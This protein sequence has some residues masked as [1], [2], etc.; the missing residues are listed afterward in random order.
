M[1]LTPE[2]VKSVRAA[3]N[4][5]YKK[6][7]RAHLPWRETQ[8]PYHILVSEVMLQQTQVERVIPYF[9][10]WVE[11]FPTVEHLSRAPL[12]RVLQL[13][14]GLGYNR[15]AAFLHRAAQAVVNEWGGV[16]PVAYDG[17]RTL[18]G[19]GEYTAKA[20]RV[21]AHNQPET[22][23]ETNV[24]TVVI[25]HCFSTKKNISEDLI[26]RVA[27]LLA[28]GQDPRE[29]HSALMDYGT[30]LKGVVGNVSRNARSYTK[31][32]PLKGSVREVRGLILKQLRHGSSTRTRLFNV[33]PESMHERVPVALAGLE[34]DGLVTRKKSTYLLAQ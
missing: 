7:R 11:T 24:R 1:K 26:R 2:Q 13:W 30:Y 8:D 18:P 34:K 29:W 28:E 12:S 16:M 20:V 33:L 10:R 17:L 4:Q 3:V 27:H 14:S 23:I 15:R 5:Y 19:V 25:Y 22:L 21:F 32:K 31:Q 6:H 9:T